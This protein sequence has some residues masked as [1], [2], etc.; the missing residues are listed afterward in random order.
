MQVPLAPEPPQTQNN[1]LRVDRRTKR[2]VPF[3][4][5]QELAQAHGTTSLAQQVRTEEEQLDPPELAHLRVVRQ[6]L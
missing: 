2:A 6:P 4:L 1:F 3:L 5:S